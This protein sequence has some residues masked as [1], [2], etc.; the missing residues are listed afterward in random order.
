MPLS[1]Q[2]QT[3]IRYMKRRLRL[4]ALPIVAFFMTVWWFGSY[5]LEHDF[6]LRHEVALAAVLLFLAVILFPLEPLLRFR[7]D[8]KWRDR[9]LLN[10]FLNYRRTRLQVLEIIFLVFAIGGTLTNLQHY[11]RSFGSDHPFIL[12]LLMLG[13]LTP[14]SSALFFSRS[15]SPVDELFQAELLQSAV[16]G[17][18]TLVVL[19]L[20]AIIGNDARPGTLYI[21]LQVA[22]V[23]KCPCC[24]PESVDP[25]P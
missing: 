10:N 21:T 9:V 2:E 8:T 5:W 22:P 12:V 20:A 19:S 6:G 23:D 18:A 16:R 17:F 25:G 13:S 1:D 7:K 14:S 3:T 15:I 24:Q 11:R 4:L